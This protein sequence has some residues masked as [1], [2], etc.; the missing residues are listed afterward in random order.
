[1]AGERKN[2]STFWIAVGVIFLISI[3]GFGYAQYHFAREQERQDLIADQF[4]YV[5]D[6]KTGQ[7]RLVPRH[8][9]WKQRIAEI[10]ARYGID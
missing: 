3:V 4:V 6:E 7:E 1:M 10:N 9:D 5:V 8:A 2:R